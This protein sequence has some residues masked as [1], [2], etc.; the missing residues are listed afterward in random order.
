MSLEPRI[1]AIRKEYGLSQD[2][3]WQIPQ[4]KQWVCKHA[5][6]EVVAAKAGIVWLE[7]QI[8]EARSSELVTSMIVTGK[9][10]ERVEWSTGETNPTNYSVKGKQPAYPWAMSEKRAKDRVIL[11]LSGMHGLI[12]S[13]A[14]MDS[15][16]APEAS[17]G[18]SEPIGKLSS[19]RAQTIINTA[20]I[21]T[22]IDAPQ[23][24]VKELTNL[25]QL[26]VECNAWMPGGWATRLIERI[27]HRLSGMGDAGSAKMNTAYAETMRSDPPPKAAIPV[28]PQ[29]N[30]YLKSFEESEPTVAQKIAGTP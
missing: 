23:R 6:L 5:A 12:Y 24:T 29:L 8:I 15:D 4:N 20:A 10:G 14:E 2:D 18:T 1:E 27:D 7:P 30:D 22:E 13:D 16:G 3:F 21:L 19:Y 11:K 9:L 28:T 17:V 25:R 26:Y